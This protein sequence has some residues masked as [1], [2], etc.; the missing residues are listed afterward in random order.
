[1]PTPRTRATLPPVPPEIDYIFHPT[2]CV[3][4]G[5]SEFTIRSSSESARELAEPARA[6]EL[7]LYQH[8]PWSGGP[9]QRLKSESGQ[10][11]LTS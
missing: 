10:L 4:P 3:R 6:S 5:R 2:S 11:D 8:W 7:H 9:L 1:M